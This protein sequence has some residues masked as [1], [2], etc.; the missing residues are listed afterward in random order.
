MQT[1]NE[2]VPHRDSSERSNL[3]S[4]QPY[5]F[6]RKESHPTNREGIV[7]KKKSIRAKH[8]RGRKTGL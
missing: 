5:P 3:K 6:T 2:D 7:K 1:H 4:P 8:G